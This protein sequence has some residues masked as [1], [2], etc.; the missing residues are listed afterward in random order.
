MRKI[1]TMHCAFNLSSILKNCPIFQNNGPHTFIMVR[2]ICVSNY[3]Y[4]RMPATLALVSHLFKKLSG[5]KC[6]S[7]G[8][9]VKNIFFSP[10]ALQFKIVENIS[11]TWE[12]NI[13]CF[14]TVD[15][16]DNNLWLLLAISLHRT[17]KAF[18]VSRIFITKR[19]ENT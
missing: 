13:F 9:L 14:K 3:I 12:R 2:I 7:L 15:I 17:E 19:N 6:K 8:P 4:P 5:L 10:T 18:H 1:R 16:I 11:I